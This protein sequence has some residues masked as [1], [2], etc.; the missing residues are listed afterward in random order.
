MGAAVVVHP[1]LVVVALVDREPSA[2]RPVRHFAGPL[3]VGAVAF[4]GIGVASAVGTSAAGVAFV[5]GAR[6]DTAAARQ[7]GQL[8]GDGT[9]LGPLC[10][11][12]V[13]AS[14]F[15]PGIHH[16]GHVLL[17]IYSQWSPTIRPA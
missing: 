15:A 9:G 5:D 3:E 4:G 6:E 17:Y 1:G 14:S 2:H 12:E 10:C 11:V 13:H 8:V 7:G 16:L